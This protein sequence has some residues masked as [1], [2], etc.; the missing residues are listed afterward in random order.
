M[1]H[2]CVCVV[3]GWVGGGREQAAFVFCLHYLTE[4]AVSVCICECVIVQLSVYQYECAHNQLMCF[5][6]SV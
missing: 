6:V 5:Q 1:R 4:A 3:G 2:C